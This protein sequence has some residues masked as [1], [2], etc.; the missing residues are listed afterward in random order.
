MTKLFDLGVRAETC[1]GC[2]IG[3]LRSFDIPLRDVNHDMI[4]AGHPRLNFEFATYLRKLP[5]HWKEKNRIANTPRPAGFE[6]QVWLVGQAASAEAS[7]K[8][9]A[10][11]A[12]SVGPASR[13]GP[14]LAEFNCYACHHDLKPNGWRGKF[15]YHQGRTVGGLVWN[16]PVAFGSNIDDA[17]LISAM[18]KL[19]SVEQNLFQSP[20][21]LSKSIDAAAND[22]RRLRDK[23]A[24]DGDVGLTIPRLVDSLR[25]DEIAWNRLDWDQAARLYSA[26][27]AIE[28]AR[29]EIGR[30]VPEAALE[31]KAEPIIDRLYDLLKLRREPERFDSPKN[32]MPPEAIAEFR[33]W[34]DLYP[35]RRRKR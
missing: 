3:A 34:F 5:P 30:Q 9:L 22:W 26:M 21:S 27:V 14:E 20:E 23:F 11:R 31:G 29:R 7:L 32:F 19:D 13:A 25:R 17:D 12:T 16:R 6:A 2:H 10:S 15:E 8:L 28:N 35:D 4:A 18:K 33:K 1:A 24:N